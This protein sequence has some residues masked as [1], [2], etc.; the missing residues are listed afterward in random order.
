M[1]FGKNPLKGD[2]VKVE[3]KLAENNIKERDLEEGYEMAMPS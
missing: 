2:T 1:L 3:K